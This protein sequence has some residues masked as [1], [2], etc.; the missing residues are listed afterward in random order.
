MKVQVGVDWS[1]YETEIFV[2]C[3]IRGF[4]VFVIRYIY[5][6][7]EKTTKILKLIE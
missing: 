7:Y 1:N 3:D 6:I 2:S 5:R 4:L